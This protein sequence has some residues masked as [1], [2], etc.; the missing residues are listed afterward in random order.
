M[1]F[2]LKSNDDEK[3][4]PLLGFFTMV[5]RPV[6]GIRC[7]KDKV[8]SEISNYVEKGQRADY[9]VTEGESSTYWKTNEYYF[10]KRMNTKCLLP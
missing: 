7:C 5:A 4:T 9:T 10:G 8:V 6:E 1:F 2:I 3:T